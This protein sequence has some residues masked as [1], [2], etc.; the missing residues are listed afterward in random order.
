M[1]LSGSGR[2]HLGRGEGMMLADGG[3]VV[4]VVAL[5]SM[6]LVSASVKKGVAAEDTGLGYRR[7]CRQRQI[8]FYR[9]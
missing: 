8:N 4:I 3:L 7:G 6:Q 5:G 9:S 2:E 1:G